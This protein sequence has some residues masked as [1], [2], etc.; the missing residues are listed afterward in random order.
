MPYLPA[1]LADGVEPGARTVTGSFV[2]A[3]VSGFTSL[4]ERLAR[5]GRIGAEVL[6]TSMD[7]FFTGL[8]D[9]LT[10]FGG[11]VLFFG[12][13]ALFVAFF[14]DDH[15][16][17]AV[18][19]AIAMLRALRQLVPL[20]TP[21]GAVRVS[22]SV[23]VA[24]GPADLVVGD[25]PQRPLFLAGPTV[26]R[27]VR[28]ES[29]AGSGETRVDTVTAEALSPTE[30]RAVADDE[31]LVTTRRLRAS[32]P[33]PA[34]GEVKLRLSPRAEQHIPAALRARLLVGDAPKEHRHVTVAFVRIRDLDKMTAAGRA[35]VL[36]RASV[37]VGEAC[38]ALDVS[39]IET[40][41]AGDG[42]TIVVAGGVPQQRDDDELR[43]VAAARRIEDSEL[44]GR[45]SIGIHRGTAF[46]GEIGHVR[47][48]T[49]A[50]TGLTTITAARLA[51][52][53]EVGTVL[54]SADVIDRLQDRYHTG[55]VQALAVKGRRD[56]VGAAAVVGLAD[57]GWSPHATG[58]LV[59][60]R[61]EL[62]VL[63]DA[64]ASYQAGR[65][66]VIAIVGSPGMG[67]T[68][69]LEAFLAMAPAP[70]LMVRGE[71]AL[72]I[73]PFGVLEPALRA[74]T[75]SAD[76]AR[77]RT[78]IDSLGDLAPL[79]GPVIGVDIPATE[80]ST[81]IEAP[82]IPAARAEL[83]VQMLREPA[84]VLV[85]EDAHW[86]DPATVELLGAIV[87]PL[88]A[89]GWLIV[90][91][92]RPDTPAL[93]RHAV[94]LVLEPLTDADVSR[95]AA[96]ASGNRP[97]SDA[98]LDAIV[99]RAGGNPLFAAQLARSTSDVGDAADV[100]LPESAERVVGARIDVLPGRLRSRLRRASVLGGR[101]ELDVLQDVVDD[102]D[103]KAEETW[104]PLAEFV[105]WSPTHVE[106]RHD[107]FRLV[108]YEGLS[109]AERSSLHRRAADLLEGRPG[110]PA[111]VLAEHS[112]FAGRP[113]DVVRWASQAADEAAAGAAFVDE[114]RLRRLAAESAKA[115]GVRGE[116]RTRLYNALAHGHEMLGE[117]DAAER[118]YR[119]ALSSA[120]PVERT[121][122]R[123]RLAWLAFRDDDLTRARRRVAAGLR[124]LPA[125]DADAARLRAGLIGLRSAIRG[126][127]G[128]R[129]RSDADARWV[130]AEAR[131]LG[132][133]ELRG[134][135]LMQ[136]AFNAD[137]TDDP[138]V[139]ELL[140]AAVPLLEQAGR[141]RDVGIL[142]LNRGVTHMVRGR[143]PSALASFELA[144]DEF[145]RCGFV[146]GSLSTDANRGGLLLEQGHPVVAAELFEDVV[147]RA[148]AA[149]NTRKALFAAASAHRARAWA[150]ETGAAIEG[151]VE[152][153]RAH[154]EAGL[155][156]E[157]DG[158]G[159]YL[160]ELLVLAGRFDEAN[161][162][163]MVVL[164][165]LTAWLSEEVVVLT[166][167]RLAAV[168]RYWTGDPT[169][170][171]ELHDVL[172]AARAD[173]CDIEIAR[174]LQALELCSPVVDPEW[175]RERATRC[176]ALGVTWM[177]PVTFVRL[178]RAA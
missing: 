58:A 134:E 137:L 172:A 154:R 158:L 72:G 63:E 147:R 53:A 15:A 86:L 119:Q 132:S 113:T 93:T 50:V 36:E 8:I 127:A 68:R 80:G 106:F 87:D 173:E 156:A 75:G 143:W 176:T 45:V 11:D 130:E 177:P 124:H 125:D 159:A 77:L 109:F 170:L 73:V 129:P 9:A 57:G 90:I 78:L 30:R 54:A 146:L 25:G 110:T 40:D 82:S 131:R 117:V 1:L 133:D 91:A 118:A 174:C 19:G 92:L 71:L 85:V 49:Y 46:V 99:H 59:G 67:K 35:R 27:T 145:R 101:V 3:D 18:N 115:A 95:L 5:S 94:R 60:R 128:D 142:H 150:G 152:C 76:P 20:E 13:D 52:A 111:A 178:Q 12:G 149:G 21:L 56:P 26:S 74:A 104:A 48:R 64:L 31:W 69:L 103:V 10:P 44:G 17:R 161:R 37:V 141:R 162:E 139:E 160:V 116:E 4:S 112:R 108:A 123:T 38:E 105:Q 169:A 107:L 22:M 171:D 24:T 29:H 70:R 102:P 126:A 81:A 62:G 168:A 163:A 148:S 153:I 14:G 41:V 140:A 33:R 89:A 51:A 7:R 151:L 164:P 84:G 97:L 55:S 42:A 79:I 28:L 43:V 32:P 122:I 39:W 155:T 136:L 23:G 167:R 88:A 175:A 96:T 138:D 61:A 65:G 165:H 98:M 83:V 6:S 121:A 47:R 16:R 166:T 114:V 100:G 66:S 120:T 144:A 157:A 2:S 135:A 34:L